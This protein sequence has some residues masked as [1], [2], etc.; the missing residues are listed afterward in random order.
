VTIIGDFF[1]IRAE[2]NE[3][4][5]AQKQKNSAGSAQGPQGA[6][7]FAPGLGMIPMI[8]IFREILATCGL[9]CRSLGPVARFPC[10]E[11]FRI[12]RRHYRR[13]AQRADLRGLSGAG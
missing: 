5:I 9:P 6:V 3:D 4:F 7:R 2:L 10:H 12:R 13:R 8:P 11:E 1:G